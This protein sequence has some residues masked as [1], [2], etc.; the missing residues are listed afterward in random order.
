MK[1]QKPKKHK[2]KITEAY[3]DHAS[4]TPISASVEAAMHAVRGVFANPSGLHAMSIEAKKLITDARAKIAEAIESRAEEIVFT[5]SATEANMLAIRG[6]IEAWQILYPEL[7]PHAIIS[8]I[9]HPSVLEAIRLLEEEGVD[10][11]KVGVDEHGIINLAELKNALRPTTVIV[12]V[13][14][15]N[16]EIGTLEPIDEIAKIVRHFKKSKK[17]DSKDVQ[18]EDGAEMYPLLHTD[19]VQAFQYLPIRVVKPAVDLMTISSGK[20]YGPRGIALL[21]IKNKT[22]LFSL[23]PGG[24]QEKGRRGGTETTSLIVGFAKAVEDAVKMRE[25]EN[26]RLL[27]I[28]EDG[29]RELAKQIPTAKLLGHPTKRLPNNLC[30]SIPGI[31]SDYLVLSLSAKKIYASS[32][33]ACQSDVENGDALDSHVILQIGGDPTDGTVRLSFGRTTTQ[34]DVRRAIQV[35]KEAVAT[36]QAWAHVHK[37]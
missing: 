20:I 29:K 33:S 36:W 5:G 24:G 13:M 30:F 31:E 35:T 4:A 25:K 21:Y 18:K 12:S 27:K 6:T 34:M 26:A 8:S 19:A 32:R 11:T 7:T 14:T 1:K 23:M 15:A 28:L 37:A 2:P 3:L 9:E 22:P 16:N 17:D 10:V